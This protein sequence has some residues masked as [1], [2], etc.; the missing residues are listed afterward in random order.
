M[1]AGGPILKTSENSWS[2]ITFNPKCEQVFP[3]HE[4]FLPM[5]DFCV[6][7]VLSIIQNCLYKLHIKILLGKESVQGF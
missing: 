4:L 5:Y 1:A 2:R 7:I 3:T 6:Q